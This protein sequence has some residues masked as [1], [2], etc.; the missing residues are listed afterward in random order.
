M[1]HQQQSQD[2]TTEANPQSKKPQAASPQTLARRHARK[3][4]NKISQY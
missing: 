2:N 4:F 1:F 3:R